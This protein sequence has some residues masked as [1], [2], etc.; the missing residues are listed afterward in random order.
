MRHCHKTIIVILYI[1]EGDDF[2]GRI[3]TCSLLIL[4]MIGRIEASDMQTTL[5]VSNRQELIR[6]ISQA[7]PNTKVLVSGEYQ[8]G[9]HFSN[10]QGEPDKPII[11]AGEDANH[12]PIIKGEGN[13][14][15]FSDCAYLELHNL[16]LTG[17]SAN[18]INIDD[19]GSFD[20]PSHHIVLK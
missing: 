7:K 3:L 9:L 10:L 17:A 8:G 20:T 6:A 11:I 18:G 1:T 14:L 4:F 16:I 12:K 15:Q 19:G 2:L 5:T 13:C